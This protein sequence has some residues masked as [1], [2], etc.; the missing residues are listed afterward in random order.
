[1]RGQCGRRH[2]RRRT[3][4]A[5][6]LA[7]PSIFETPRPRTHVDP[8]ARTPVN[9]AGYNSNAPMLLPLPYFSPSLS[10]PTRS[11][12]ERKQNSNQSETQL[13]AR[14]SCLSGVCVLASTVFFFGLLFFF[15]VYSTPCNSLF[16]NRSVN[17]FLTGRFRNKNYCPRL[18]YAVAALYVRV[19]PRVSFASV[20]VSI[21]FRRFRNTLQGS[22]TRCCFIDV[23]RRAPNVYEP[24]PRRTAREYLVARLVTCCCPNAPVEYASL[25][26]RKKTLPSPSVAMDLGN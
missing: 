21:P 18:T 25:G 23:A 6:R 17:T 13:V 15:F 16:Y 3:A 10:S 8:I 4:S 11:T 2:N 14:L 9:A 1:M 12:V 24:S 26:R 5:R 19:L 20:R 22:T 7:A